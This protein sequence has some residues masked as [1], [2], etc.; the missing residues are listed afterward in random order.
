M[1][2]LSRLLSGRRQR[3]LCICLGV[4]VLFAAVFAGFYVLD[5]YHLHMAPGVSVGGVDLSG[6]HIFQAYGTLSDSLESSLYSQSLEVHLPE[7]TLV[8]SP[9]DTQP[10]VRMLPA[11]WDAFRVGRWESADA[12]VLPLA[13]YISVKEDY[14][15]QQLQAYAQTYDTQLTQPV[16]EMEGAIPELS[17]RDFREDSAFPVVH[18]TVGTPQAH[19]DQEAAWNQIL[20]FF[21]DAVPLCR[22]G[23][24]QLTIN[25]TPEALPQEPEINRIRED[26][27]V[28]PVNDSLDMTT[29]QFVHGSYGCSFDDQQ[30]E[31]LLASAAPGQTVT[32]PMACVAP[33][34][35]G[36]GVYFRDVLGSYETRH[37]NNENR[38][39]NL[40]L[41]CAA[42]DG[43][44]LQPG[45]EFSYNAVVG[46]RTA[47]RGYKPAPAYSGNRLVDSVGGGVCQGSTTL[48]NCVLLADLEVVFRACHGA[49][50]GY[51]PRGLDAA[52]NYLT[53][54]FKFRNNFHFPIMIRA[55]VSDG[56][57]KMQILGTDEKDYYIV[58]ESRSGEDDIAVYARSYKC[59]Y[60]KETGELISRDLEAYSTYYKAIG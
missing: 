39:T 2:F 31:E 36:E 49:S 23:A 12:G 57:V 21:S 46:E 40:R 35:L 4:L 60:S 55:E 20:V 34:I 19:L 50:V 37:T 30:L 38:N 27:C 45:E 25:V 14:I 32:I 52:V 53:T 26:T 5:P 42:L 22:E 28:E 18:I 16:W 54:D 7:E 44:I 43:Y 56:Y 8:L 24:Y 15:R 3:I 9:Q 29:Y 1:A 51:V 10:H 6:M 48:Y 47:E 58:M 17:T 33:E 59:K 13:P 41:L 11:L